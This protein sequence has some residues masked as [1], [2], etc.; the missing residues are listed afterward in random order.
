MLSHETTHGCSSLF[1]FLFSHCS[2]TS[3]IHEHM[4]MLGIWPMELF[5]LGM[6]YTYLYCS[7]PSFTLLQITSQVAKCSH[8]DHTPMSDIRI[9][10]MASEFFCFRTHGISV[11]GCFHLTPKH[12]HRSI[13]NH[14]HCVVYHQTCVFIQF[15]TLI[16]TPGFQQHKLEHEWPFIWM[17]KLCVIWMTRMWDDTLNNTHLNCISKVTVTHHVQCTVFTHRVMFHVPCDI[18]W[19]IWL[20]WR[21]R[22]P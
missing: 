12:S 11:T 4:Q 14:L 19:V 1:P 6:L 20:L 10:I 3:C 7:I 17:E 16:L 18:W 22:P 2:M 8:V 13:S 5:H 21:W 9:Y 15:Q